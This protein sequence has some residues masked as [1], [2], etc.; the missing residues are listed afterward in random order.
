MATTKRSATRRFFLATGEVQ[1]SAEACTLRRVCAER[2][3]ASRRAADLRAD[4]T[5]LCSR[6][7]ALSAVIVV[8][9]WCAEAMR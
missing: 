2:F 9:A 3:V 7:V 8:L 4:L 6:V 5:A 1:M